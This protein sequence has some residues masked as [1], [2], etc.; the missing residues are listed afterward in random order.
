MLVLAAGCASEQT[1]IEPPSKSTLGEKTFEQS[2]ALNNEI[3]QKPKADVVI[4]DT[5]TFSQA[6]AKTLTESPELESFAW[7]VRVK[8][9]ERIQ[10][11]LLPNPTVVPKWRILREPVLLKATMPAKRR[12]VSAR[13]Y[14]LGPTE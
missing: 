14:C 8:E 12:F 5:L 10:A 3:K 7:Q 11:S 2:P 9:A 1:L 6:L 4:S 13:R